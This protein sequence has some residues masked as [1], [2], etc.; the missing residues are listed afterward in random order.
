MAITPADL[1]SP[2]G[3]IEPELFEGED[4]EGDNPPNTILEDRLQ[5]YIDQ[6]EAKNT[7]I[8]FSDQDAADKAWA[9]H[10]AFSA[11]YMVAVARPSIDNAQ[12]AV[13]G[14]Q[15]YSKDQRDALLDKANEYFDE[16]RALLAAVPTTAAPV[17]IPSRTTSL[18]FD[19]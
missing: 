4:V 11:A 6:A 18:D 16:Y 8:G 13:I 5:E 12:V 7:P 19:Y 14:S 9:L 3:P 10:L 1:L 17:G 2:V 15:S